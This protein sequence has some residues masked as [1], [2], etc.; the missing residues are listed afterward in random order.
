M[1]APDAREREPVGAGAYGIGA[2]RFAD[3]NG[4]RLHYVTRGEG[5]LVVLLHG[6]P[7]FWYAWR[8]QVAPLADAGF[9]VV[10]PDMRGYAR[11]SKPRGVESYH[12][13]TLADDIAALVAH[14]GHATADVVG[15]DWGGVVAWHLAGAHP[16]VV[17]RLAVLNAPHPAR[18]AEEFRRWRQLRRSWYVLAFQLPWLPEAALR[19][20]DFA[21]VTRIFERDPSRAGAFTREDLAR[22]RGAMAEPGALT[23][24][25]NYYRAAG[26]R[27]IQGRAERAAVTPHETL[28]LWGERDRHLDPSLSRGLERSVPRLTTVRFPGASHWIMADE[29]E[30]VSRALVGFLRR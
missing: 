8:H 20:R 14:L 7:E 21:A 30:E 23:A 2:S 4:V 1:M 18:F 19:A 5:P 22:Y 29:P 3:V 24:M 13:D 16:A 28:L 27:V 9:T 25:V 26:R 12:V 17:R 15:H 6:F 10:A 11:S